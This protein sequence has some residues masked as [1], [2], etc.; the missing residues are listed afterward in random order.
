MRGGDP[1][2]FLTM[3]EVRETGVFAWHEAGF[4]FVAGRIRRAM[5]KLPAAS[6]ERPYPPRLVVT[7][8]AL[9]GHERFLRDGWSHLEDCRCEFC[10]EPRA[11]TRLRAT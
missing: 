6:Q 1:T 5:T 8:S 4:L 10:A 3:D 11:G 9:R 7:R 2:T